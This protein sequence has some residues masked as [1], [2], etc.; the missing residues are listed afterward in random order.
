MIY[1]RYAMAG[2]TQ[3]CNVTITAEKAIQVI[4]HTKLKKKK[5]YM[6]SFIHSTNTYW[7]PTMGST[8]VLGVLKYISEQILSSQEIWNRYLIKFK[9]MRKNINTLEREGNFLI[10]I[11]LSMKM[12]QRTTHLKEKIW[13]ECP[14]RSGR[15]QQCSRPFLIHMVQAL[16]R[17]RQQKHKKVNKD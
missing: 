16:A 12:L 4:H 7:V 15:K 6:Y 2:V 10:L 1:N 8:I 11:K 3:K 5:S 13:K 9:F 17:D 14:L